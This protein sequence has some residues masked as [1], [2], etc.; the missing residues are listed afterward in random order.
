MVQQPGI[1]GKEIVVFVKQRVGYLRQEY[2][3]PICVV[4]GFDLP[5]GAKRSRIDVAFY[6]SAVVVYDEQLAVYIALNFN[7]TVVVEPDHSFAG[8][9]ISLYDDLCAACRQYC[10]CKLPVHEQETGICI[11]LE[12]YHRTLYGKAAVYNYA[13]YV[14]LVEEV[15]KV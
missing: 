2:V 10:A 15:V 11:G 4:C 12:V 14:L 13:A 6:G 8:G 5:A 3:P 7:N 1:A 9:K